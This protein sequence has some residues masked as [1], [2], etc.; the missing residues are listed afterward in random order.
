MRVPPEVEAAPRAAPVEVLA[1]DCGDAGGFWPQAIPKPARAI[2]ARI[3]YLLD[4]SFP[5]K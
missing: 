1:F 3:K 5:P 4:M 2:V